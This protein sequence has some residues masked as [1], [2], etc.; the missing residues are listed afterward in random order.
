MISLAWSSSKILKTSSNL[1]SLIHELQ[2]NHVGEWL[3]LALPLMARVGS[4]LFKRTFGPSSK[5]YEG[6]S[7]G[8][9]KFLNLEVLVLTQFFK[10]KNLHAWFEQAAVI[11]DLNL[12][13]NILLLKVVPWIP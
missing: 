8:F 6:L 10:Y 3:V 5:P 9:F 4:S 11:S 13:S 12:P 7:P 2:K 1:I